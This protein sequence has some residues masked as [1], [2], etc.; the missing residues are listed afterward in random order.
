VIHR[1]ELYFSVY[2]FFDSYSMTNNNDLL[3]GKVLNKTKPS[4]EMF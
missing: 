2:I 1:T 4:R 3:N